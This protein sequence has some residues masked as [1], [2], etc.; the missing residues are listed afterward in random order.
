MLVEER[1]GTKIRGEQ[2]KETGNKGKAPLRHGNQDHHVVAASKRN[3][4][5]RGEPALVVSKR[6][7]VV[8]K[9]PTVVSKWPT[10]KDQ[11]NGC[12]VG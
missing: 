1:R 8:S 6:P 3:V 11:V 7:T 9:W 12:H 2:W 5:T 4:G 10:L